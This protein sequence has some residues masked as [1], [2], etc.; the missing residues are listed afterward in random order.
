[1]DK[2]W[3]WPYEPLKNR[4]RLTRIR[5]VDHDFSADETLLLI[6]TTGGNMIPAD[7]IKLYRSA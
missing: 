4:K 3:H 6:M 5:I 7:R 1:V 2:S